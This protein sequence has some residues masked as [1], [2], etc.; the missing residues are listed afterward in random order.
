MGP[1]IWPVV[2]AAVVATAI[3]NVMPWIVVGMTVVP[4]TPGIA[5]LSARRDEGHGHERQ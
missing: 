5:S 3:V 2:A 4:V 1:I